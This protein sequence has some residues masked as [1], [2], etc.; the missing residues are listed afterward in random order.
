MNVVK[1]LPQVFT[2]EGAAMIGILHKPIN[3]QKRA[4]LIVVGGPQTRV[5]SHRQFILLARHLAN[6]GV[7]VL[8]FDYRGM[9]DSEGHANGFEY[10]SE[11]I[12][13][14]IDQLWSQLPGVEE[15]VLWGLCDAASAALM[16]AH[17]DERVTGLVLLNPW[18]R[19]E[20]SEARAY[21]KRYYAIRLLSGDFW[22]R[23]L[24]G[25]V[26]MMKSTGSL[27]YFLRNVF[28]GRDQSGRGHW[29]SGASSTFF[30]DRMLQG[31]EAFS[32]RILIITS[33]DDLTAAEFNELTIHS[34]RWRSAL[35][36]DMVTRKDI[37]QANHTFS[38]AAW[39]DQVA[40]WCEDWVQSW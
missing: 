36:T 18:V 23:F 19:S 8:R 34:Q 31:L 22:E 14:A 21:L 2:C 11:D 35:S 9:G 24:S 12:S 29:Q 32:G 28:R 25:K 1:E 7:A 40:E 17:Q 30:I 37:V 26:N 33:G 16:Y 27:F 3:Y 4:V 39:R 10:V 6:Q 20:A 38:R 13:V 15:I 5:G